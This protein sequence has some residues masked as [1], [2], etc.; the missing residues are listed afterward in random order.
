MR[1]VVT[2][3]VLSALV[4]APATAGA[5][6]AAPTARVTA[7]ASGQAIQGTVTA[8]GEGSATAGVRRIQLFVGGSSVATN[9]PSDVKQKADVE[10]SWNT[11]GLS[12]GVYPVRVVVTATGGAEDDH[13]VEVKVDNP[14]QMPANVTHAVQGQ[15]V[16]IS[17]SPNPESDLIG[18]R[19]ESL[20]DDTW[21]IVGETSTTHYEA[22]VP[23]G[24]YQYR[25]T[26]LRS[27][28]TM[29]EGRPSEP[30]APVA[31]TVS[32]PST[33]GPGG[34]GGRG[35]NAARL[36]GKDGKATPDDVRNTA[37]RFAGS[38]ISLGGLSLPGRLGFPSLPG[39]APLEWGS[40]K[41]KLPYSIPAGGVPMDAAPP[42][43]AALSTTRVLPVDAL[44][45]VAVGMLMIVLAAMAQF[46]AWRPEAA[47]VS[48]AD[49]IVRIRRVQDRVRTAWEKARS[50]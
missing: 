23:A 48:F 26:A 50:R 18:Y 34:T 28:P 42:R 41:E 1:R 12:N 16:S 39:T 31:F 44:R 14:P 36:F 2:G 40:Y 27:S 24:S 13:A 4:A 35:K 19:I 22:E 43:L 25:V 17:W 33:G 6:Q 21:V 47:A 10:Y 5:M 29:A 20:D 11:T 45:W 49:A 3:L 46:F 8:R 9:E 32:D 7:P 15:T 37:N 38:G 30:T